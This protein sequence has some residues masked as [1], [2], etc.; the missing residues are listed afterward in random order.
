M[1]LVHQGVSAAACDQPAVDGH[2]GDED[3]GEAVREAPPEERVAESGGHRAGNDED[4]G[5]VVST[6]VTPAADAILSSDNAVPGGLAFRADSAAKP[7]SISRTSGWPSSSCS[8]NSCSGFPEGGVGRV[9][10][11][12]LSGWH[13]PGERG[14]GDPLL[15]P[16][17]KRH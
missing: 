7:A 13:E 10:N 8:A 3:D 12:A 4:E 1:E 9:F 14:A 6:Q 5:V 17:P 16:S 11:R 15:V 2:G